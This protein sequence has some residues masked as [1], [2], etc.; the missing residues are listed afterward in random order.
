MSAPDF[1]DVGPLA[2]IAVNLFYGWGYNFY[3]L[4]NQ[5]RADDQMIRAKA[6]WLLGQVRASVAEA[7]SAWRHEFLPP[8][9]R[10]KPLPDPAAVT[11]AQTIEKLGSDIGALA[12]RINAMPVPAQDR[13]TQLYRDEAAILQQLAALDQTLV[14]QAEMLRSLLEHKSGAWIIESRVLLQDGLNAIG[15]TLGQRQ[16]L[17]L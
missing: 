5:L 13:M 4:E 2:Q 14:G 7:E 17:L 15:G 1:Y 6:G 16:A 12:G 9:S 10:A 8:P 3:R 11:G